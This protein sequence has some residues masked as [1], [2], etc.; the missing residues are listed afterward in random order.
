MQL[1]FYGAAH[2]VTGSCH[3]LDTG[4][5]KILVDCGM[6]QGGNFNEGKNGSDFLFNPA[7]VDILLLTHAHLDH[8]GRVPKLIKDGFKGRIITTKATIELARLVWVDAYHIMKYNNKKYQ[9][10]ILFGEADIAEA[11]GACEPVDYHERVDLGDGESVVFK[12]AGHIFGAAFIELAAGGKNIAFSGDVGNKNVPILRETEELGDI[13]VLICE[14][15]YGDRIHESETDRK[16]ILL[17]LIKKGAE[18]G[19]TIMMPAFSL[20]RTQEILYHL[21]D[22][23]E[24]DK[25]LPKIPIYLDSPMAIDAIPIYK[26]YPEYYDKEAWDEYSK[27]ADFLDFPE[28]HITHTT[29][30]S[31]KINN[32]RGAK[33]VIAGAGMMNGGRIIHHAFRYLSDPASTLIIVGYQAHG[34]LGRR[35]YEGAEKANI[36]GEEIPVRCEIKAIGALSAHADQTKLVEWIGGAAKKPKKIYLIHGESH[37]S[38]S[39]GHK[40][41]EVIGIECFV[42]EEGETVEI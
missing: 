33:M 31:K 17:D 6:F 40:V 35:L 28:L 25:E 15:T 12:D 11:F 29:E 10:P 37:A 18:R 1:S 38:A 20:E 14:S 32:I 9:T 4:K 23:S 22:I 36:F 3:L 5:K 7:E 19:G 24:H 2:E 41:K 30:E 26:K 16:K 21:H 8:T 42:P 39:L 34:T 13:D 27:G